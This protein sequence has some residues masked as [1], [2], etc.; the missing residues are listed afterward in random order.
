MA[1]TPTDIVAII[2]AVRGDPR[3]PRTFDRIVKG[4]L[5]E[6]MRG[7][8][9]PEAAF[10][11]A[12]ARILDR[13]WPALTAA[14]RTK[15]IDRAARSMEAYFAAAG[16]KAITP[17]RTFGIDVAGSTRRAWKRDLVRMGGPVIGT[18]LT[19]PDRTFINQMAKTRSWYV[20]DHG[21]VLGKTYREEAKAIIDAG[22]EA[23]LSGKQISKDLTKRMHALGVDQSKS[24]FHNVAGAAV[25]RSRTWS[26]LSSFDE[27]GIEAYRYAA[28]LD[29]RTSDICRFYHGRTWPVAQTMGRLAETERRAVKDPEAVKEMTPWIS[30]VRA[31]DGRQL[32]SIRREDRK[33]GKIS[34]TPVA[35]VRRSAEGQRDKIGDYKQLRSNEQLQA[36]G[37]VQPPLHGG[38]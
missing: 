29:E 14:Q 12:S 6:I 31:A 23:G 30:K 9:R 8:A 17:I 36:D 4:L 35:E 37:V 16:R 11:A 15:V 3:D 38:L 28:I 24:Y 10:R 33:T 22:A 18:A 5:R 7:A 25:S 26:E 34:Y 27:A 32:L 21:A 19:R 13:D 2:K 20:K 1:W